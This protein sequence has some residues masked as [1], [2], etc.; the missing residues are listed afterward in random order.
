MQLFTRYAALPT[1]SLDKLLAIATR[2][3]F[4]KGELLLQAG[5]VENTLYILEKGLVK[6]YETRADGHDVIFW[7]GMEGDVVLSMNSY[8]NQQPGY[9]NV[10]IL[11]DNSTVWSFPIMQL[12]EL[13][14][15][16]IHLANWGRRVA[17]HE[18]LRTEKVLL[19]RLFK[20]ATERYQD[21]S[22]HHPALLQ[23]VSLGD[24][25]S[26]L[27]MTQVSLSRIRALKA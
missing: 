18:L 1:Q 11:E 4:M 15:T 27:G 25:A 20:T 21:L 10:G 23:R 3:C 2:K 19:S 26:F 7:F 12:S 5:K 6:A 13:Y 17:E 9:E 14:E 22:L 24:I 16:D 8:V